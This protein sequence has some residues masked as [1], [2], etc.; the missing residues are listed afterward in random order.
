MPHFISM[1]NITK[2]YHS[3]KW[4]TIE[5]SRGN[6]NFAG[7]DTLVNWATTNNKLVRGHTTVWY[8][9]LPSWV[10]AIT[11]KTTLTTVIQTHVSTE[12]GRY[13]GKILQWVSNSSASAVNHA[14]FWIRM[15]KSLL[16]YSSY[17][18]RDGYRS[19]PL[20]LYAPVPVVNLRFLRIYTNKF[21]IIESTKCL[22]NQEVFVVLSSPKFSV[23]TLFELLSRQPRRLTQMPS[24][25]LTTT[26]KRSHLIGTKGL[27]LTT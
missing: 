18:W 24:C 13:A 25:T 1:Y 4:D 16:S 3:G 9:Q 11:D 19:L 26:S 27:V 22:M 10:S 6:F 2:R 14:D 15:C 20:Q 12:I 5:A 17:D 7:L 23:R 21:F 8:S